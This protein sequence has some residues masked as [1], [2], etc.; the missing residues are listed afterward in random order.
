MK[1][2]FFV[3]MLVA[4]SGFI[5]SFAL[6]DGDASKHAGE[7]KFKEQCAVCHPDGGNIINP[8]KTLHKRDRMANNIKTENDIIHKMRN[9]GPGMTKFDAKSLSEDNAHEIAAYILKTF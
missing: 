9:P 8:N 5:A 3:F 2:I 7:A 4:I 1:K 6:A